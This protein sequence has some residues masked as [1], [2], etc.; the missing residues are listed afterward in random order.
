MP[1][2][3]EPEAH[4]SGACLLHEFSQGPPRQ[5]GLLIGKDIVRANDGQTDQTS[6]CQ[7]HLET[8]YISFL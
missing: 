2:S 1:L 7:Q 4:A 6:S 3:E 8:S 5:L